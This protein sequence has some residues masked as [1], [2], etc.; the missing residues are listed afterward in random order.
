MV[1]SE[2]VPKGINK[3]IG[4]LL[5]NRRDRLWPLVLH[6]RHPPTRALAPAHHQP[7]AQ[8]LDLSHALPHGIHLAAK[9]LGRHRGQNLKRTPQL[10][11]VPQNRPLALPVPS[12]ASC[13]LRPS[14]SPRGVGRRLNHLRALHRREAHQLPKQVEDPV[15]VVPRREFQGRRALGEGYRGLCLGGGDEL[16]EA[17][18]VRKGERLDELLEAPH[19]PGVAVPVDGLQV[20]GDGGQQ[21]RDFRHARVNVLLRVRGEICV[22]RLDTTRRLAVRYE[23]AAHAHLLALGRHVPARLDDALPPVVVLVELVAKGL[24]HAVEAAAGRVGRRGALDARVAVAVALYSARHAA[25]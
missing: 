18:V 20:G 24:K 4:L 1:R 25:V 22:E 9:V 19:L 10:L 7:I 13:T 17:Q 23:S 11:N 15:H 14:G 21:P 16:L 2:R 3:R 5:L 12:L 6:V 8:V